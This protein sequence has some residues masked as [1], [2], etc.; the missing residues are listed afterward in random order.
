[1]TMSVAK[2]L[3]GTASFG[4]LPLEVSQEFL[5]LLKKH[6]VKDLD[7]AHLYVRKVASSMIEDGS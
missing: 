1:M 7:T 6:N 5:D 3:F 2:I 4:S